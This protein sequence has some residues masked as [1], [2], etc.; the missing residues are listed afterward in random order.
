MTI[1]WNY[2]STYGDLAVDQKFGNSS[3]HK[4]G[5]IW[6]LFQI[7]RWISLSFCQGMCGGILVNE[8][9][10]VSC[11][12]CKRS[13]ALL[14]MSAIKEPL[15]IGKSP[16][17]CKGMCFGIFCKYEFIGLL[18]KRVLQKQVPGDGSW[19][20]C[21]RKFVVFSCKLDM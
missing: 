18:C 13:R 4:N 11:V 20:F 12:M 15:E 19:H 16:S 8:N 1:F 5:S 9:L 21:E 10:L 3:L 2:R 6:G 7:P 17:F 14:E